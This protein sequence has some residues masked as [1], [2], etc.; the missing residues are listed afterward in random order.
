LFDIRRPE[1]RPALTPL[2]RKRIRQKNV[3]QENGVLKKFGQQCRFRLFEDEKVVL[4]NGRAT[5]RIT[6]GD[7]A[8]ATNLAQVNIITNDIANDNATRNE[9]SATVLLTAL[10]AALEDGF[11]EPRP[12]SSYILAVDES[13]LRDVFIN[14]YKANAI[15]TA[16]ARAA[17]LKAF[18]RAS[19][20]AIHTGMIE[21][22]SW[23]DR[24]WFWPAEDHSAPLEIAAV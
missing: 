18:D 11:G 22:G 16:D 5:K 14:R 6:T 19:K 21:T 3:W 9:K 20:Q 12:G 17:A 10:Y 24:D 1:I 4:S 13:D 7:T 23:D 8:M 2:D 15:D